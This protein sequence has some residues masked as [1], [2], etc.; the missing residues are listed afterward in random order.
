MDRQTLFDEGFATASVLE[1]DPW[2]L[3]LERDEEESWDWLVAPIE[4]D[5]TERGIGADLA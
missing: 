2:S 4:Q 1:I 3:P 5:A